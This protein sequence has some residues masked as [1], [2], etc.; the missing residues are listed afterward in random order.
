MDDLTIRWISTIILLITSGLIYVGY[1]LLM[2]EIATQHLKIARDYARRFIPGIAG[3]I[4]VFIGTQ[5]LNISSNNSL[6]VD[7]K[8]GSIA[9]LIGVL[10][11]FISLSLFIFVKLET[12]PQ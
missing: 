8:I 7:D 9:V 10:I 2:K 3:G 11:F 4:A 1:Y 6:T 5:I 12:Q